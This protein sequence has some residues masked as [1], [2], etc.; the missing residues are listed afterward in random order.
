MT[1]RRSRWPAAFRRWTGTLWRRRSRAVQRRERGAGSEEHGAIY[2]C[3]RGVRARAATVQREARV[4]L[5]GGAGR[6]GGDDRFLRGAAGAAAAERGHADAGELGAGRRARRDGVLAAHARK[7]AAGVPRAGAHRERRAQHR[8]GVG[9]V[10]QAGRRGRPRGLRGR[11]DHCAGDGGVP[12]R[13]VPRRPLCAVERAASAAGVAE[14]D[15]DPALPGAAPPDENED[16]DD[17]DGMNKMD[18][19]EQSDGARDAGGELCRDRGVGDDYAGAGRVRAAVPAIHVLREED[20]SVPVRCRVESAV[21]DAET[22]G[23]WGGGGDS[24][25]RGRVAHV[26]HP[27]AAAAG[28]VRE[29]QHDGGAVDDGLGGDGRG[30]KAGGGGAVSAGQR[31]DR[32]GPRVAQGRDREHQ[33]QAGGCL[34]ARERARCGQ[35]DSVCG[36]ARDVGT[37]LRGAEHGQPAAVDEGYDAVRGSVRGVRA[38]TA[39]VQPQALVDHRDGGR[40]VDG[41]DRVLKEDAR[42]VQAEHRRADTGGGSVHAVSDGGQ[43]AVSDTKEETAFSARTS[44]NVMLAFHG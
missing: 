18:S 39:A 35:C 37:A 41:A 26:R 32:A 5:H 7:R 8:L 9:A 11:V 21:T 44:N 43:E 27:C 40:A 23:I 20:D 16:G 36:Q 1:V 15:G 10:S 42:S 31:A 22:V 30:E 25:E 33:L 13:V 29:P 2:G 12:E 3:V 19:Q 17:G 24:G 6:V 4:D 14:C 28:A 38:R 34:H